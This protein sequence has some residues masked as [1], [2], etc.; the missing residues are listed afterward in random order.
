MCVCDVGLKVLY[1]D[2]PR[3]YRPM[4]R[5]SPP[6][7]SLLQQRRPRGI[8][9]QKSIDEAKPRTRYWSEGHSNKI[10]SVAPDPVRSRS[11]T[12]RKDESHHHLLDAVT[13]TPQHSTPVY[14]TRSLNDTQ[15]FEIMT[16]DMTLRKVKQ[17]SSRSTDNLSHM[18]TTAGHAVAQ[19]SVSLG[20]RSPYHDAMFFQRKKRVLTDPGVVGQR[21]TSNRV[22]TSL[23]HGNNISDFD[24]DRSSGSINFIMSP[25]ILKYE[26]EELD[27][28]STEHQFNITIPKGALKKKGTI[29]VQV[30]LALHGPFMFPERSQNVSPILWLCSIPDTKFRKPIMVTLPHCITGA[31][32]GPL[33]RIKP[34][35]CVTL[36]FTSASLKSATSGRSRKRQFEFNATEGE[37]AFSSKEGSLLTKHLSPLCIVATC[38]K[39]TEF[40]RQI[41]LDASYCIVPVL[42]VTI[43]GRE[44]NIH[45]C[46]TFNLQ[47]CIQVQ[48]YIYCV[49]VLGS[50]SHSILVGL[51]RGCVEQ[52]HEDIC[53]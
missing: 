4:S 6:T 25:I 44:W 17:K 28:H 24:Q 5:S 13:K 50:I 32:P 1:R 16:N 3:G 10:H 47:S 45:F 51:L 22:S 18:S 39:T 33:K 14:R 21:H 49:G 36:H 30:G 31:R 19:R 41:A 12:W 48:S 42:P 35:D 29:E 23:E 38:G 27:Y 9:H 8:F 46:V 53:L 15:S 37:E 52:M 2:P 7:R 43:S 34:S 20:E 40:P 11:L 26:G